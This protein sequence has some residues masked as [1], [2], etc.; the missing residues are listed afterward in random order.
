MGVDSILGNFSVQTQNVKRSTSGVAGT[1]QAQQISETEKLEIFKK[2]IW[3]E[4]DSM[5]WGSNISVQITD[6]AFEKDD[7]G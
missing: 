2:E 7:G 3:K 1:N 5:S 4:I 6:S